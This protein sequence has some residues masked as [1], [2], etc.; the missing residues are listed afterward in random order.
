MASADSCGFSRAFRLW[1]RNHFACSAG[2][3]R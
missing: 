2:L 1:L 3:P